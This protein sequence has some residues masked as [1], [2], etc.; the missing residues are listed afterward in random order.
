MSLEHRVLGRIVVR[1]FRTCCAFSSKCVMRA[2][3][4]DIVIRSNVCLFEAVCLL[5]PTLVCGF[6]H[7]HGYLVGIVAN[8]GILFGESAQKGAHFAHSL[9]GPQQASDSRGVIVLVRRGGR[10][11]GSKC[12][13]RPARVLLLGF[14]KSGR[15]RPGPSISRVVTRVW[16]ISADLALVF[17]QH[18][19]G[20]DHI[21]GGVAHVAALRGQT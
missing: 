7:I 18:W 1:R 10:G 6:A 11:Q 8:N 15:I 21:F 4:I 20:V 3:H 9:A 14:V 5:R 2:M 17:G 19:A 13:K 16:Q 12:G